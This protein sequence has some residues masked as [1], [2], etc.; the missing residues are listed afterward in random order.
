MARRSSRRRTRQMKVTRVDR[1]GGPAVTRA[2]ELPAEDP[3]TFEPGLPSLVAGINKR[4]LTTS[5]R[6][7]VLVRPPVISREAYEAV[8]TAMD[9]IPDASYGAWVY[10]LL[11]L[12]GMEVKAFTPEGTEDEALLAEGLAFGD[13]IF[14]S[15]GG[16]LAAGLTVAMQSGMRRGAIALEIDVADSL[17]EVLDMDFVDPQSVDFQVNLDGNHKSLI[18]VYLPPTGGDPIPF[19]QAQFIYVPILPRLGLPHGVVPFL[20]L[21]DTAY[22]YAELRDSLQKVAKS[23]GF[24]RIKFVYKLQEV[25]R[26]ADKFTVKNNPDGT[27]TVLDWDLMRAHVE[28][29]KDDL[30]AEIDGIFM[31]D[32]WVLPDLVDTGSVGADHVK[33]S[34]DFGQLCQIFDQDVITSTKGQPAV[35]GRQWGSDLSSTGAIQWVIQAL[36]IEALREPAAEVIEKGLNRWAVITGRRGFFEICFPPIRREDRKDEA[37]AAKIETET[38]ILQE[39][40]GYIDANEAAQRL[41]GHDAVGIPTPA[42]APASSGGNNDRDDVDDDPVEDEQPRAHAEFCGCHS[43]MFPHGTRADP[44]VPSVADAAGPLELDQ[45]A[46]PTTEDVDRIVRDFDRWAEDEGLKRFIGILDAVV[47]TSRPTTTLGRERRATSTREPGPAPAGRWQWDEN[48]ARYRYP[49]ARAGRLG[50]LVPPERTQRL[51]ERRLGARREMALAI[52]DRYLSGRMTTREWQDAL[53]QV[54]RDAQLEARV[55]AVGGRANMTFVDFGAVGGR[56]GHEYQ[57]LGHLGQ[58]IDSGGLSP[59]QIRV[60]TSRRFGATVRETYRRG[61]EHVHAQAGYRDERSHLEEGAEHCGGCLDAAGQGWQPLG[62]LTPIG[63][64][65]CRTGCRCTFEYRVS[66]EQSMPD[67]EDTGR[68]TTRIPTS[69]TPRVQ[70]PA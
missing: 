47:V 1:Q 39:D 2:P 29:F 46:P 14:R 12:L 30:K 55:L 36:G 59:A 58:L 49:S 57:I 32:S 23:Q 5:A 28:G 53:K 26:T 19:N 13:R 44:F 45:D 54:V 34:M 42:P 52:T 62:S 9:W 17:D 33:E 60:A 20:S 61:R 21:A 70:V 56:A 8:D 50:R 16:G 68:G 66:E 67:Y 24:S 10:L 22:P 69:L 38:A 7:R 48:I 37:E 51:F 6:N 35:F 15:Y 43:C 31:D 25:M 4:E 65:D 64:R 27:F 40:R 41:V 3:Q 18:P 11:G 63:E